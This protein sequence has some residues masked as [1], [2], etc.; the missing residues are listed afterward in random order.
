M[1]KTILLVEDNPSDEK[2]TLRAFAKHHAD[3]IVIARDGVEAL[4]Y[5][6]AAGRWEGRDTTLQPALVLIDLHMPRVDGPELLRRIRGDARTRLLPV[7]VL[8]SSGD[9]VDVDQCYALGANAYVRKPLELSDF[10]DA[11]RVIASFWLG[12]NEPP[13]GG[14]SA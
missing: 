14:T 10:A 4:E 9:R 7:V 12:L 5:L 11:A 6:H 1:T 3:D 2:L 13:S 8:T